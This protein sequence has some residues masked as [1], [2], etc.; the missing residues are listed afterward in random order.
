MDFR[1]LGYTINTDNPERP[2][3]A[4]NDELPLATAV[5]IIIEVSQ[6]PRVRSIELIPSV[7]PGQVMLYIGFTDAATAV[8]VASSLLPGPS[9][10][11]FSDGPRIP[12]AVSVADKDPLAWIK[13]DDND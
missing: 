11:P 4:I 2:C 12:E 8:L 10:D 5:E 13:D 3:I 1:K 7:L 6:D 9:T